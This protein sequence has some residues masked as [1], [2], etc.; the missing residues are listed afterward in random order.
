M[1]AQ[2]RLSNCGAAKEAVTR[3]E[4][5]EAVRETAKHSKEG[6]GQE[7]GDVPRTW[8]RRQAEF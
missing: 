8:R 6:S 3:E 5:C 2:N 1:N 4:V 7:K